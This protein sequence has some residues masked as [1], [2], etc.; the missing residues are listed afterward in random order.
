MGEIGHRPPTISFMPGVLKPDGPLA[1]QLHSRST[2]GLLLVSGFPVL[3]RH[4]SHA[5]R[6]P[7]QH[8]RAAPGPPQWLMSLGRRRAPS[9]SPRH[10]CLAMA[11]SLVLAENKLAN[12]I[13]V[14]E[15]APLPA[16]NWSK[17]NVIASIEFRVSPGPTIRRGLL[18]AL[19][20]WST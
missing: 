10:S 8:S 7:S 4:P 17:L 14:H 11:Q 20:S 15:W 18:P 2:G 5:L 9:G 16:I 3:L 1:A 6:G 19:G 12:A 13:D